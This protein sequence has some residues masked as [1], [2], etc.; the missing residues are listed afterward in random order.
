M[1]GHSMVAGRHRSIVYPSAPRK[2][3]SFPF[4]LVCG[5]F[6]GMRIGYPVRLCTGF[7]PDFPLSPLLCFRLGIP[8]FLPH[9][10][11]R[12]RRSPKMMTH[13]TVPSPRDGRDRNSGQ[14]SGA[15]TP[16]IPTPSGRF[17]SLKPEFTPSSCLYGGEFRNLT[18]K[19]PAT[20]DGTTESGSGESA[21]IDVVDRHSGTLLEVRI[22]IRDSPIGNAD[23]PGQTTWVPGSRLKVAGSGDA[24]RPSA[25][26]ALFADSQADWQMGLAVKTMGNRGIKGQQRTSEKTPGLARWCFLK[27]KAQGNRENH[28]VTEKTREKCRIATCSMRA[29]VKRRG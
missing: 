23:Q 12:R 8:P 3:A 5:N 18:D 17:A 25:S 7:S 16:S 2:P 26:R 21:G 28:R 15:R 11:P 6:G 20:A 22:K 10:R 1:S 19:L 27:R 29:E 13:A 14:N 4:G 24:G 9:N